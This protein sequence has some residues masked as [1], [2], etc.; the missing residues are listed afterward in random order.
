MRVA[1]E[2]KVRVTIGYGIKSGHY[3]DDMDLQVKREFDR[4][5]NKFDNFAVKRL[6]DT[7]AKI[8]VKDRDFFV[9]TSFNWLSFRGDPE[10]Q[11]REEWGTIVESRGLTED[12]LKQQLYPRLGIR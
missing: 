3:D 4:L 2:R 5:S 8:L 7:H 12:F 10:K 9:V 1:L 11:F 6:G